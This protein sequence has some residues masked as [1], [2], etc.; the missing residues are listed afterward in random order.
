MIS[1]NSEAI[2]KIGYDSETM[3]MKIMFKQGK[4]Y[5][6]CR[7]PQNLFDRF[8]NASSKGRFYDHYINGR[9]HC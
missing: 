1:V 7:V 4:S 3:R 8:L 5:T 2:S 6:F 9:Y